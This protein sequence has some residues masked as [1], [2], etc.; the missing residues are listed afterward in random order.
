MGRIGALVVT[1][2]LLAVGA[3]SAAAEPLEP[4]APPH[5]RAGPGV[6]PLHELPW[7]MRYVVPRVPASVEMPLL[8]PAP[9]GPAPIPRLLQ[10]GPVLPDELVPRRGGTL[11]KH[12]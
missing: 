9:P 7:S 10:P 11:G 8:R 2:C 3:G 1:G 5:F 6:D 12:R 4:S